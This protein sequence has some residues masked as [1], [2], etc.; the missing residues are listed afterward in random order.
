MKSKLA[1][2]FGYIGASAVA[3]AQGNI[4]PKYSGILATVGAILAALGIHQA[5]NTEGSK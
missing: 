4:F 5:S 3:I 1:K 2:I